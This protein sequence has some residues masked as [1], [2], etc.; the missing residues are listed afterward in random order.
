MLFRGLICKPVKE[1]K[2]KQKGSLAR[3]SDV[4]LKCLFTLKHYKHPHVTPQ[5]EYK[6]NVEQKLF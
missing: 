5:E 6:Y 4:N 1:K 2:Q 3:S